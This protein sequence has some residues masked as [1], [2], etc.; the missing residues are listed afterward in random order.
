MEGEWNDI[1]SGDPVALQ[2]TKQR[3][4]RRTARAAFGREQLNQNRR[5]ATWHISERTHDAQSGYE[6]D[7]H[8]TYHDADCACNV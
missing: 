4:R 7:A 8:V 5:A 6:Q 3:I 2:A 1:D